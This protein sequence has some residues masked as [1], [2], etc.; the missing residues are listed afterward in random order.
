MEA[1]T[2]ASRPRNGTDRSHVLWLLTLA[3]ALH[4]MEEHSSNWVVWAGTVGLHFSWADFYMAN[5]AVVLFGVAASVVGWRLPA[6][7]L[8]FPALAGL[9]ALLFHLLASV[10]AGRPNPGAFSAVLLFAPL[11]VACFGAA[12]RDGVLSPKVGF[13]AVVLGAAVHAVPLVL[14][15]I[16]PYVGY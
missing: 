5:A 14:L 12:R 3:Y 1:P 13:A 6:F 10:L 7:S 15:A 11:T 4:A 16:K 9:N 2:P 8:A